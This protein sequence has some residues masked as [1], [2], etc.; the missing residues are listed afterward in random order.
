MRRI[1]ATQLLAAGLICWAGQSSAGDDVLP[2]RLRACAALPVDAERLACYDR[3]VTRVGPAAA[4]SP[5]AAAPPAAQGTPATQ[6]GPTPQERFGLP[7]GKLNEKYPAPAGS[8]PLRELSAR[9]TSARLLASGNVLIELDNGQ[10]WR[11]IDK[12]VDLRLT[13]GSAVTIR[14]GALGSYWMSASGRGAHVRRIR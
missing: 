11:Q 8:E 5:T 7:P 1:R 3:E 6:P 9:V 14:P 12:D 10:A 13:T 2:E 4:A